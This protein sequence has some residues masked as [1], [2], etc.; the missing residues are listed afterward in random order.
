M[1]EE[2]INNLQPGF[3]QDLYKAALQN[4]A[5]ETNPLRANN[6]AYAAREVAS[7]VLHRLAPDKEVLACSWYKNEI[8]NKLDGITHRQ[9]AVYATQG[10]LSDE[11]VEEL[12]LS[13]EESH[14][15]F[16]K[17]Y[18][19]LNKFTHVRKGTFGLDSQSTEQLATQTTDALIEFFRTA[20][21]CREEV[22]A[23]V[24]EK[25]N[26]LA[27]EGVFEEAIAAV[28]ILSTHQTIEEIETTEINLQ[29]IDSTTIYYSAEGYVSCELQWG[30]NSDL[31]NDMGAIIHH[32]LPF[33][34]N[35]TASVA[36]PMKVSI[37]E[38]SIVVDESSWFGDD[39]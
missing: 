23:Q 12:G 24:Y 10:G 26:E 6:F 5:D 32:S 35:L 15:R 29:N 1:P 31:R 19:A 22:V 18:N 27:S 11:Y 38:D 7:T 8:E 37:E 3:E 21:E 2:V 36:N 4:L 20:K 34:C 9:R 25:I 14:S 13:P 39:E 17:A 33:S 28:D 16:M 30:S